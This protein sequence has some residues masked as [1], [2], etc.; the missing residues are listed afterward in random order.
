MPQLLGHG[1]YA[2]YAPANHWGPL[3]A[4]D[5]ASVSFSRKVAFSEH[6]QQLVV[7]K[8]LLETERISSGALHAVRTVCRLVIGR[9]MTLQTSIE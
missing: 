7:F 5:L 8:Y 6:P 2:S 9:L 1:P 4:R 3:A